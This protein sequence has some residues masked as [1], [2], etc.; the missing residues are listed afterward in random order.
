MPNI[1]DIQKINYVFKKGLGIPNTQPAAEYYSENP[2]PSRWGIYTSQM[3]QQYIPTTA[4]T[5]LQSLTPQ[6]GTVV[7]RQNSATYPYIVKYTVKTSA[8]NGLNTAYY[9]KYLIIRLNYRFYFQYQ[10]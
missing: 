1:T 4:P 3:F 5:D 9:S 10:L 2:V 6:D 7:S 8:V